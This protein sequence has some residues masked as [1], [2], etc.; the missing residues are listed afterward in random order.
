MVKWVFR[1]FHADIPCLQFAF[2]SKHTVVVAMRQQKR[3]R[4]DSASILNCPFND[5]AESTHGIGSILPDAE[6]VQ[7]SR[8]VGGGG[9][10]RVEGEGNPAFA[11][12]SQS[13][14]PPEGALGLQAARR[15]R[16]WA[17]FAAPGGLPPHPPPRPRAAAALQSKQRN[18][19]DGRAPGQWGGPWRPLWASDS[20]LSQWAAFP[21]QCLCLLPRRA[22]S[23]GR[24]CA[25]GRRPGFGPLS[26][27]RGSLLV[28][29]RRVHQHTCVLVLC[30]SV[31]FWKVV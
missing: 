24:C 22:A 9:R 25:G 2:I 11:A 14:H 28:T 5:C 13:A 15:L 20:T 17:S 31:W 18:G 23:W 12:G 21:R 26:E 30:C 3:V 4:V 27:S 8:E 10:A 1:F 19:A 6:A 16:L 29:H 7:S